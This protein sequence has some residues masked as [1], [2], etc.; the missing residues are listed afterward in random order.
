LTGHQKDISALSISRDGTMLLSVSHKEVV[1]VWDVATAK[2]KTSWPI[3]EQAYTA[4]M[5]PDNSLVF[6]SAAAR[7]LNSGSYTMW[8]LKTTKQLYKGTSETNNLKTQHFSPDG[9]Y[10]ISSPS[11][12]VTQ[13]HDPRSGKIL[14]TVVA[15]EVFGYVECAQ[16]SDNGKYLLTAGY[17][18]A[19]HLWDLSSGTEM[20]RLSGHTLYTNTLEF[21]NRSCAFLIKRS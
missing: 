4:E 8:D 15:D 9:K 3:S 13:L 10:F 11:N 18:R 19:G 6:L 7:H 20:S 5:S 12:A 14:N 2:Q 16:F 17:D 21:S 1:V